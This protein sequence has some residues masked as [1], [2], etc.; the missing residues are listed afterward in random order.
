MSLRNSIRR[1]SHGFHR[2]FIIAA[3]ILFS[4]NGWAGNVL[5]FGPKSYVR[6]TG[7][8][9]TVTDTFTVQNPSGQFTLHLSNGGLQHDTSEFVSS[10]VITVNGVEVVSPNDLNQNVSTLDKA[11]RLQATNT[12]SVQMRGKPGGQIAVQIFSAST[13]NVPPVITAQVSPASNAAGWNNTNVTVTFTCTDN[14]SGVATCPAPVTVTTEGAN[15]VV[16]GTATDK[17]GNSASTSVSLKI[18]KT[19]PS[20]TIASPANNS[21]VSTATVQLTGTASDALSGI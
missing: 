8:P 6:G 4:A 2:A 20:L 13:D 17:A 14:S 10:T 1:S 15:Q 7:A 18:D 9:V 12:I 19:P 11:V 16:S 5:V 3:L 21:T